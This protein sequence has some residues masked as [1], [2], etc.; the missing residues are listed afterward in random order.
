MSAATS[1][2][3][4]R[5]DALDC[6]LARYPKLAAQQEKWLDGDAEAVDERCE[7]DCHEVTEEEPGTDEA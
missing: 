5:R 4:P 2:A 7:C 3:C 1:C 6:V